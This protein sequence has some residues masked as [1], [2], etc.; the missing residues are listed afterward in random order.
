MLLPR[1]N[2]ELVESSLFQLEILVRAV[3]ARCGDAS[4]ISF[5]RQLSIHF[6]LVYTLKRTL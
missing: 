6:N 4:S 5:W 3:V 2:C 1:V